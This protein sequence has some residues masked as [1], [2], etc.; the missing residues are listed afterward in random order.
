MTD[1]KPPALS[2]DDLRRAADVPV[3][4][5]ENDPVQMIEVLMQLLDEAKRDAE[6]GHPEAIA[7]MADVFELVSYRLDMLRGKL[8]K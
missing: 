3:H 1:P 6:T 7:R 2:L 4:L 5:D 8:G